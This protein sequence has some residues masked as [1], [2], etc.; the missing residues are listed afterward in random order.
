MIIIHAGA[1]GAILARESSSNLGICSVPRHSVER[2]NASH[3]GRNTNYSSLRAS[4]PGLSHFI[5]IFWSSEQVDHSVIYFLFECL[6]CAFFDPG[7]LGQLQF[8]QFAYQHHER[9]YRSCRLRYAYLQRWLNYHSCAQKSW[10]LSSPG[11]PSL[12]LTP[13]EKRVYAQLLKEADPDGFGAVSG[14][15]AVKFFEKTRLAPDV[16]GQVSHWTSSSIYLQVLTE[17]RYG[18]LP[19]LR[20]EVSLLL[21]GLALFYG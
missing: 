2:S 3:L 8:P 15:V 14:D 9:N 11:H 21:L 20:I 1:V 6:L 19:I 4:F 16:L 13:E 18:R 10:L 17:N 12:N 7:R 5:L